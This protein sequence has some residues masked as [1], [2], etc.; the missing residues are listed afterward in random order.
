VNT[1]RKKFVAVATVRCYWRSTARLSVR[2]STL[3]YG[4]TSATLFVTLLLDVLS[5]F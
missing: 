2:R 3:V 4:R 1:I 5:V